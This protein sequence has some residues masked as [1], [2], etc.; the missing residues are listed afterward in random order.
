MRIQSLVLIVVFVTFAFTGCTRKASVQ[1]ETFN[2]TF[3]YINLETPKEEAV[4]YIDNSKDIIRNNN[5]Y[6]DLKKVLNEGKIIAE[7]SCMILN[8]EKID[9]SNF[10]NINVVIP[11]DYSVGN[12]KKSDKPISI[13]TKNLHIKD[14]EIILDETLS[15]DDILSFYVNFIIFLDTFKLDENTTFLSK[16]N[17]PI[18]F[19]LDERTFKEKKLIMNDKYLSKLNIKPYLENMLKKNNYKTTDNK[20]EANV[21]IE[22][23]HLAFGNNNTTKKEYR[24][25]LVFENRKGSSY[26]GGLIQGGTGILAL[27]ALALTANIIST[28]SF[29]SD[30]KDDIVKPE[31]N[32]VYT[33]NKVK[34]VEK[35]KEHNSYMNN[36]I[37]K[38]YIANLFNIQNINYVNNYVSSNLVEH[39][40]KH[41]KQ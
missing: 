4:F 12:C 40:F 41:K 35:N 20:D 38:K 36:Y 34:I 31:N 15:D 24:D 25:L 37:S 18:P 30:I 27:D 16:Y 23:E 17:I 7:Y 5:I 11:G 2:K 9:H 1:K 22:M 28:I 33:I 19:Y 6:A 21:I 3:K 29:L 26:S 8:K 10:I 39:R 32:L 14:K 13:S